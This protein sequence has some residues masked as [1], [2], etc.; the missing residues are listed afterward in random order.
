MADGEAVV[1]PALACI[2]ERIKNHKKDGGECGSC[3]RPFVRNTLFRRC[4]GCCTTL[5]TA[6]HVD[7]VKNGTA[8]MCSASE[9]REDGAMDVEIGWA[10]AEDFEG[11]EKALADA[12]SEP[13]LPTLV[14]APP[15]MERRALTVCIAALNAMVATTAAR[16]ADDAE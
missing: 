11:L 2:F 13:A 12:C 10:A 1:V 7:N 8:M 6:C 4:A 5:C 3:A 15:E 16:Y 14:G 9:A